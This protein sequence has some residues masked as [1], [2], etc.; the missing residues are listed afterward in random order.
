[1]NGYASDGSG[2]WR[3][4]F[5]QGGKQREVTA[6]LSEDGTGCSMGQVDIKAHD[7]LPQ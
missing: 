4:D 5:G 1:M 7:C 3:W 6:E 2:T